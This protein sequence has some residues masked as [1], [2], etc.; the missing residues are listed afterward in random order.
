MLQHEKNE[1]IGM[2]ERILSAAMDLLQK[3]DYT[4]LTIR[5]IC[6]EANCSTATFYHYFKN[7]EDLLIALILHDHSE[8]PDQ[9]LK[10]LSNLTPLEAIVALCT[11]TIERFTSFDL[12]VLAHLLSPLNT[13]LSYR[14]MK[15]SSRLHWIVDELKEQLHRAEITGMF[16]IPYQVDDMLRDIDVIYF[17]YLFHWVLSNGDYELA[18][19]MRE[20]IVRHLN[21]FIKPEYQL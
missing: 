5:T 4:A 2:E 12:D 21:T 8:Q 18:P 14:F 20:M 15:N 7:K 3:K 6:K 19:L 10:D 1:P 17:G 9:F 13:A 11:Y 16:L